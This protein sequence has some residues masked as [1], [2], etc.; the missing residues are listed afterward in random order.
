MAINKLI[1]LDVDGVLNSAEF[2]EWCHF[3]PEFQKNGGY[4]QISPT[5]VN[6][7]LKI[8]EETG[9]KIVM[10]SGWRLW[11][12][13]TT[14]KNL[15]SKRDLR[16]ILDLMVG[17]TERTDDRVRGKEIKYFLNDCRKNHFNTQTEAWNPLVKPK[18]KI[19]QFPKYVIIDDDVDMLDEQFPFFINTDPEV[20][21]TD[22]DVK[23]AIKILND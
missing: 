11:N 9:A 3:H 1:F 10:S 22:E 15:S 12:F 23:T 13:E 7:V 18:V 21:I 20:G 17:I 19:A 14:I 2:A 16:P 8:C 5:L 6:R 4:H